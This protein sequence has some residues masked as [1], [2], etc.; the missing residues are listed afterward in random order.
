MFDQLDQQDEFGP[1]YGYS[2]FLQLSWNLFDGGANRAQAAQQDS[3]RRQS[4]NQFAIQREAVRFDVEQSYADLIANISSIR[5][6]LQAIEAADEEVRLARLRFQA[7]VGTQ[8]DRLNAETRFIRARGNVL[9]AIIGYNQAVSS[10]IRA[11]SNVSPGTVNFDA[12]PVQIPELK[13][14][15]VPTAPAPFEEGSTA[16]FPPSTFDS[17]AGDGLIVT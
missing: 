8:T 7:G 13:P 10:L 16:P 3:L 6:S 4:E 12:A 9:A 15:E 11:V 1:V 14:E 17:E 5:T 2:A